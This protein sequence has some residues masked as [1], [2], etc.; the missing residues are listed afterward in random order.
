MN[1][2]LI[3]GVKFSASC[4]E[5]IL[6]T[7]SQVVG[8][9]ALKESSFN[10]DHYDLTTIAQ[11][12]NIS[13]TYVDDINSEIVC[14]WIKNKSPDIIFCFG[15]SRLLKKQ[16]L[17]IAPLGVLGFHPTALPLNRGRHPII[18]T[19]VLGLKETASTFFFMD[20]GAD[21]GDILSQ[22]K[23][24]ILDNDNASTLYT[25]ITHTALKQIREFIPSLKDGSFKRIKQNQSEVN[26]W[27]KRRVKDGEIDWRMTAR[28]I[29]NLVRALTKPYVG[30]HFYI[31]Q[32]E[33]K[34]WN[35]SVVNNC[36][37]ENVEPGKIL[38]VDGDQIIVK[39]GS[40]S[41]LLKGIEGNF[42]LKEGDYL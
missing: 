10:A 36:N 25:K 11:K 9:C 19:L 5:T 32:E 13:S 37:S 22:E 4:L 7:N 24:L 6:E 15:W 12:H 31:N 3:G 33:I 14:E 20:E 41:I 1:I 27:R 18:W 21:S 23:I 38:K 35:T 17:E 39:C 34:V 8:V 40:G 30:A 16:V 28:N 2:V 42:D 29:F 26:H